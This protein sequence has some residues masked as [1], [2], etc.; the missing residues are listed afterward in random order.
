[1]K[2]MKNNNKLLINRTL[3]VKQAILTETD[4]MYVAAY[5]KK[6][7]LQETI[8]ENEDVTEDEALLI[9]E[10]VVDLLNGDGDFT[11]SEAIKEAMRILGVFGLIKEG[12]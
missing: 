8:F 5:Y 10:K 12:A 1:M 3:N 7:R 11:E 2:D 4:M 6:A 9:A